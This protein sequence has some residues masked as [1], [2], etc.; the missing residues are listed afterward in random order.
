MRNILNV[1]L[2]NINCNGVCSSDCGSNCSEMVIN[3]S[4]LEITN[5]YLYFVLQD[6]SIYKTAILKIN[7]GEIYF[8]I[9]DNII[10]GS[11]TV[12][13]QLKA[14]N[15]ESEAIY[16][17]TVS[18]TSSNS[19]VCKYTEGRFVYRTVGEAEGITEVLSTTI[20]LTTGVTTEVELLNATIK[21]SGIYLFTANIP[22]NY[23]GQ[24]GRELIVRL[25]VN[26]LTKWSNAG[27]LNNFAWTLN[28]ALATILNIS[29]NDKITM[30]IQDA[31][32]KNYSCE[33]F[34]FKYMPI[35]A[36]SIQ[37]YIGT[38]V[39]NGGGGDT[40]PIG[41]IV[42]WDSDIIPE[43]WLLLNGQAVSRTDYKEL[44]EIYGTRYGTG[45][46]SITFNLPDRRTRVPVGKDS[47]DSDFD[48]LGKTGGEK[49]HSLKEEEIPGT[50]WHSGELE[51]DA[52]NTFFNVGNTYGIRT[53]P[54]NPTGDAHNNLQPYI[55]TNFIVKAKQSAGVV[56][57]VIDNLES[58]SATD[59]LSAKQGKILN[60]K[61]LNLTP[62]L[63]YSGTTDAL[64]ITL[65][66]N[67][68]NY[69]YVEVIYCLRN[70]VGNAKSSKAPVGKT[71]NLSGAVMGYFNDSY[72][73]TRL[74]ATFCTISGTTL[75]KSKGYVQDLKTD[76]TM[77]FSDTINEVYITRVIGYKK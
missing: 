64:T 9:P 68:S 12:T 22:V 67:I 62:V 37:E 26:G 71:I 5:P 18:Y 59:A 76:G 20:P 52:I 16:L 38:N 69:E 13:V 54:Y 55:V 75:T 28:V 15:Y 35:E 31:T 34:W 49:A 44:F 17:D 46:G 24:E 10:N 33:Q 39:V 45:D 19:V 61:V 65:N 77:V 32:G 3:V 43:N 1:D 63:L 40:L 14:D 2:T 74:Y 60:D 27:V 41:A 11:G 57:N 36:K 73:A 50:F 29:A 4:G 42:E 58:A 8:E 21:R 30:T 72:Y 70:T 6:G 7:N 23:Y 25:R 56:A 48:T 51:G 47:S 66:D 53:N